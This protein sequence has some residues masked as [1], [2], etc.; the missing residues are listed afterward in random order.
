MAKFLQLIRFPNLV[1]I[2]LTQFLFYFFWILPFPDHYISI[3]LFSLVVFA[4]VFIAAGGNIINDIF[5]VQT[6][7]INKPHKQFIGTFISKKKAFPL[8]IA[9]NLTGIGLGSYVSF[10]INNW[11]VSFIFLGIALLLFL[12]SSYLKGI[13]I[14]GNIIVSILVA[15][16]ILIL[17]AFK[18][19]CSVR[20]KHIHFFNSVSLIAIYI[21]MQV[22]LF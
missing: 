20:G 7:R 17:I 5:D 14:L 6:D 16:S 21:Y 4:T 12:Y 22:L 2:A 3:E 8:Y 10:M 18:T 1:M 19:E 9:I 13:P 15:S 11:Q